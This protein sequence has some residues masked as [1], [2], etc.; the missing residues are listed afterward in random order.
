M[1]IVSAAAPRRNKVAGETYK[2]S[3]Y[4]V[5]CKDHRDAT[6]V[7]TVNAKGTR[8]AKAKCPTCQTNLTRFLPKA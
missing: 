4:C 6:G 8:M 5:K 3:F 1:T 7:V 2:G